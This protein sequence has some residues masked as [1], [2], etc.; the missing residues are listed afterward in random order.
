MVLIHVTDAAGR[1]VA[2][3]LNLAGADALYGRNW[4]CLT[5]VPFL[6]FEACYYQ[7]IDYAIRHRLDRVEAGAQ[8]P[9][10]IQR[11]YLP[12]PTYS[13]HWVAHPGLAGAIGRFIDDERLAMEREM[14][15]LA[16]ES[17]Y[18]KTPP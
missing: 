13:A 12:V 2:G 6:H 17:P 1:A 4:G 9:H 8:G 18:R 11:G 10:K 3:A 15:Y 14:A 5:E 7:A 16:D